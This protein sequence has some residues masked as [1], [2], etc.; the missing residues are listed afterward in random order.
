VMP[1]ARSPCPS[2]PIH[3]GSGARLEKFRFCRGSSRSGLKA[4]E[5]RRGPLLVVPAA[6]RIGLPRAGGGAAG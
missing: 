3:L 1:Q 2:P 4:K 5:G 6:S